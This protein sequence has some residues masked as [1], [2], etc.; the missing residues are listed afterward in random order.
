M[1]TRTRTRL[2]AVLA[3]IAASAWA[4][5]LL[6]PQLHVW[7]GSYG[8]PAWLRVLNELPIYDGLRAALTGVGLTDY[9]AIFGAAIAPSFVLLAIALR[10]VTRT[11]GVLGGVLHWV[12]MLSAVLVMVSYLT[13]ALPRPWNALWGSEAFALAIVG[14]LAIACA[15]VALA[16]RMRP[17]WP[18]VMLMLLLPVAVASTVLFG[19]WPHGSLILLGL[20]VS[21]IAVGWPER[22]TRH[23]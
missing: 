4:F 15:V 2:P 1:T 9:Y 12:S 20:W 22:V 23:R 21:V 17:V 3:G 5:F 13:H 14:L 19:Y 18:A 11:L 6:P 8:M 10:P 7:T 16:R